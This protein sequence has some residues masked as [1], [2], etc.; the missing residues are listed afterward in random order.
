MKQEWQ[1]RILR[2]V[3]LLLLD[4]ADYQAA[5]VSKELTLKSRVCVCERERE[6][7]ETK[8]GGEDANRG[9]MAIYKFACPFCVS[10]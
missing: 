5:N 10:H 1:K 6:K 4:K 7:N 3:Q 2:L 8:V 9:L